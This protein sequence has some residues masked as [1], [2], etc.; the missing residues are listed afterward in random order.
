MFGLVSINFEFSTSEA[1]PHG[2]P[3]RRACWPR[4]TRARARLHEESA[5]ALFPARPPTTRGRP[6]ACGLLWGGAGAPRAA[7]RS[8]LR[9]A[10]A[11]AVARWRA[12]R[13]TRSGARLHVT[14]R[15]R[16]VCSSRCARARIADDELCTPMH[17]CDLRKIWPTNPGG[18]GGVDEVLKQT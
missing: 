7:T 6:A 16:R 1:A 5:A 17:F 2:D 10:A 13:R 3:V 12:R 9:V 4:P 15:L 18:D 11:S 14:M 8:E